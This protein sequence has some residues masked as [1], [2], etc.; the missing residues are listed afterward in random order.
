MPTAAALRWLFALYIALTVGHLAFVVAHEPFAF[1]AWNVAMDTGAQPFS[2]ARFFEFWREQYFSS[3]PR[4]GQPLTYLAYKLHGVAEV[5]TPLAF[6]GLVGAAFVL[7][8][9]R[10]PSWRR[11]SD[12]ALLTIATGSLW[13]AA[14]ELPAHLFCRA[15][16]ANYVWAAAIQ[17]WFV[18]AIRLHL[19]RVGDEVTVRQQVGLLFF[20]VLAGLCNE[21]TGPTLVAGVLG[22]AF[23]CARRHGRWPRGLLAGAAG[24]ALGFLL[25]FFAPGQG[26][27]YDGLAQRASLTGRLLSR[28]L[29]QNLDI[30]DDLLFA[31]APLL[32][33]MVLAIVLGELTRGGEARAETAPARR[34]ALRLVAI[35]LA[36]AV[37]MT[38]TIFVS[39][40]L[41]TRFYLHSMMLLLAAFLAV[42]SAFVERPRWWAPFVVVAVLAS[43]YA[44]GRT[45]PLYHRLAAASDTRLAELAATAPGAAYTARG[46]EQVQR[47]W[48]FL[49]D[50]FRDVKKR[51]LITRYFGLRAVLF[52]G[53]DPDA[54]LWV[55]DL[56]LSPRPRFAPARCLEDE[57]TV[58][59]GRVSGR[60]VPAVQASFRE[61]VTELLHAG[62][63]RPEEIE[64]A[65]KFTGAPPPLPEGR[66]LA[67]RWRDGRFDELRARLTREGR[68]RQRQVVAAPA[69][70]QAGPWQM[71]VMLVGEPPRLLGELPKAPGKAPELAFEPWRSGAYWVLA[72]A[73]GEC[74]IVAATY[75]SI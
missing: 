35:A 30:F 53:V 52:R 38:V 55:T 40:K 25:L 18:A 51:E 9:G 13:F 61:A 23:W 19:A 59:F 66:L 6:L 21:H 29:R 56:L 72:C 34:G 33:L 71:Y 27:R 54:P 73:R 67:A 1:D 15:Y 65:V 46:W 3:N 45:I 17:L 14:P 62:V 24:A 8:L 43:A 58:G 47:S 2:F 22:A 42:L 32:V 41:G 74:W 49:G 5:G 48:W 4:I 64:L 36:A 26:E 70:A 50:D 12:L 75:F 69:L 57:P 37:A 28:G 11:G 60:D 16:A 44:A 68:S 7:G 20:G 31:A 39:P 63:G 10:W